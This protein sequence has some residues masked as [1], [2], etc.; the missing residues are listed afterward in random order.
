MQGDPLPDSDHITRYCGASQIN[1]DGTISG[2]AFRSR[3]G[4]SYLSVNWLEFLE[5]AN[6]EAEISEIRRVLSLKLGIG[7]KAKIGVLNVGELRRYI[8][9]ESP[10]GRDL[11]V[12]HQPEPDDPSHSG[13]FNVEMDDDLIADLITEIVQES[14]PAKVQLD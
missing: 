8:F 13:V 14:Y 12:R 6:R 5:L 3:E 10:D 4:E 1:E 7:T 2:A 11:Q 9:A